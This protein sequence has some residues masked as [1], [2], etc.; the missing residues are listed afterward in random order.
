MGHGVTPRTPM[1]VLTLVWPDRVL[2]AMGEGTVR[3]WLAIAHH[4]ITF[5]Q[6]FKNGLHSLIGSATQPRDPMILA[7]PYKSQAV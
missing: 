3:P 7:S 1:W 6:P 4:N 2:N 5:R